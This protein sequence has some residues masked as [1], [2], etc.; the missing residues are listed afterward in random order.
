MMSVGPAGANGMTR[1]V[2]RGY[3]ARRPEAEDSARGG[4][5]G[6][7]ASYKEAAMSFVFS[8]RCF[9]A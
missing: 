1:Q 9:E 5:R 2:R 3:A 6:T 7:N 4:L 8:P